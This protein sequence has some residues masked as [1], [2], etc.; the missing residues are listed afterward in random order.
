MYTII[1]NKDTHLLHNEKSIM[2]KYILNLKYILHIICAI[3]RILEQKRGPK[4][5]KKK[6]LGHTYYTAF[7]RFLRCPRT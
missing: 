2:N 3:L 1:Y 7:F 6:N 5:K 4:K